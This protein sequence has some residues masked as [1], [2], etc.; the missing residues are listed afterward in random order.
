[1]HIQNEFNTVVFDVIGTVVDEHG[2]VLAEVREV[3]ARNG[4]A[5]DSL[6]AGLSAEWTTRLDRAFADLRS[7]RARWEPSDVLQ[8]RSLDAAM[9]TFPALRID[10]SDLDQLA[11]VGHRLRP[12]PDSAR[13]LRDLQ[14]SFTVVALSNGDFSQL[15]DM[16][17]AGGLSW[18]CVLSGS[19]VKS[20]KPNPEVYQLAISALEL[21]PRRSLFIACH[22]WDLR[23]AASHGFRTAFVQRP[24]EAQPADDDRFD[25]TATDLADL[26]T[27]LI[28][29]SD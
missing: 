25:L 3:L 13:A 28:P 22:P 9:D 8:R 7:G 11:R 12:W 2:S 21:D 26:V 19:M 4:F 23:A 18:H 27:Q 5:D 10:R 16:S 1:M 24:G 20:V 15:A 29:P 17:A 6:A 14:A